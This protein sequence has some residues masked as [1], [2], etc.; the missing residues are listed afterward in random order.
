MSSLIRSHADSAEFISL[1][2][3]L[4]LS[5]AARARALCF[6]LSLSLSQLHVQA[7]PCGTTV[8]LMDGHW[9]VTSSTTYEAEQYISVS[10]SRG[11]LYAFQP[12]ARARV[13]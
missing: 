6:S 10:A 11:I 12:D 8:E 5:L 13:L 9:V 4:S 1:S 7:S 3:S 2:L